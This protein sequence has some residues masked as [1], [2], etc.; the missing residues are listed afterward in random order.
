MDTKRGGSK[1]CVSV[2][3]YLGFKS[4]NRQYKSIT[5]ILLLASLIFIFA[6]L[7]LAGRVARTLTPKSIP[8]VMFSLL[9]I[10]ERVMA[11]YRISGSF[12]KVN[13]VCNFQGM[14]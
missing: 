3:T 7:L 5:A 4:D 12:I 9:L 2:M 13:Q 1:F 6:Q 10:Y 11:R 8:V 14:K